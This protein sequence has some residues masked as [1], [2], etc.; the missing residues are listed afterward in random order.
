MGLKAYQV[1]KLYKAVY[2]IMREDLTSLES[3]HG[4]HHV[5][6]HHDYREVNSKN[7]AFILQSNLPG[8]CTCTYVIGHH[9]TLPDG[10]FVLL[11]ANPVL[12][13]WSPLLWHP[14]CDKRLNESNK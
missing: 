9:S 14:C 8:M 11:L 2:N 10:A 3:Y 1:P 4:H 5:I 12:L 7:T 13:F 6:F